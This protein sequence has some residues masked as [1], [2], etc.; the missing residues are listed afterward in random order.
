M[1]LPENSVSTL[2]SRSFFLNQDVTSMNKTYGQF[3]D[4]PSTE[5]L[6]KLGF[7]EGVPP[8]VYLSTGYSTKPSNIKG[9]QELG[10][11]EPEAQAENLANIEKPIYKLSEKGGRNTDHIVVNQGATQPDMRFHE[12]CPESV[13]D[14][15]ASRQ[16]YNESEVTKKFMTE[17]NTKYMAFGPI[18]R[19]RRVKK[20][21]KIKNQDIYGV[22]RQNKTRSFIRSVPRNFSRKKQYKPLN[23][24]MLAGE[25]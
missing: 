23:K 20:V 12:D 17:M 25:Y 18:R 13:R 8:S 11:T 16:T 15:A 24:S 2:T 1:N 3:T 22:V 4:S 7:R 10:P 5:I 9:V 21:R 6:H 19:N 14:I